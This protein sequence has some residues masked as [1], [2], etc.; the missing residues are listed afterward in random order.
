MMHFIFI[1][2][3]GNDV[4]RKANSS[5]FLYSTSKW[6]LKQAQAAH[7]INNAFDPGTANKCTVQRWFKKFCK[8]DKK[9]GDEECSGRPSEAD[10]Q[11]RAIIK[12]DALTTTWEFWR[13]QPWPFYGHLL[14]EVN[15]K[16]KELDKWVLCELTEN[17][18]IIILKCHLFLFYTTTMNH[19]LIGLWCG[20][21]RI[22]YDNQQMTTSAARPGRNFTA[23]SKVKLT[24]KK[25]HGYC[26][27]VCCLCD[28]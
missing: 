1:L 27:V 10:N 22:F 28:L 2:D 15:W 23:F 14:F 16:V 3:Y 12:A 26:L 24:P 18:K 4:S 21:K 7:N 25:G 20:T 19:V 11:L 13:T 17:Q 8:G 5:N 6:V 9:L